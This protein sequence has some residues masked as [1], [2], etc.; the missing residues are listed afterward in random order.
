MA[1]VANNIRSDNAA[2]IGGALVLA[3]SGAI[4][5]ILPCPPTRT[6]V[7]VIAG[8][9]SGTLVNKALGQYNIYRKIRRELLIFD[10]SFPN[11]RIVALIIA[12]IT[13]FVFPLFASSTAFCTGFISGVVF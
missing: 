8:F 3:A 11:F 2:I 13:S 6:F 1:R 4:S 10:H 7:F 12:E 5:Y 9:L